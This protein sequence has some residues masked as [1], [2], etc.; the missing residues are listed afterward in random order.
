M[1]TKSELEKMVDEQAKKYKHEY[2][3]RDGALFMQGILMPEVEK[4]RV[5]KCNQ[6]DAKHAYMIELSQSTATIE[7]LKLENQRIKDELEKEFKQGVDAACGFISRVDSQGE[8]YVQMVRNYLYPK[9]P[10]ERGD[11]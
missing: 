6:I 11:L 9:T 2:F 8:L 1:I 7:A 3:F 10:D 5:E 4:L